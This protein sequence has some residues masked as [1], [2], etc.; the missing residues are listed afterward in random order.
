MSLPNAAGDTPMHCAVRAGDWDMV[1]VLINAGADTSAVNRAG[2]SPFDI[3]RGRLIRLFE[4]GEIETRTA[5]ERRYMA[6]FRTVDRTR[7]FYDAVF[8]RLD[9]VKRLQTLIQDSIK[10]DEEK[11]CSICDQVVGE[12]C[13]ECNQYFCQTCWADAMHRCGTQ[14]PADRGV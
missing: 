11:T 3:A 12:L 8:A 13:T 10:L 5:L 4:E 14:F 1:Q 9:N 7:R 6:E 2:H